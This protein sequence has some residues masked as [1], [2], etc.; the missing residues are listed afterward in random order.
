VT[1]LA[2]LRGLHETWVAARAAFNSAPID[3][4][5]LDRLMAAEE[6]AQSNLESAAVNALPGLLD[7][8]DA[9]RKATDA[10][11]RLLTELDCARHADQA[12]CAERVALAAALADASKV[13]S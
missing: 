12:A 8:L 5:D 9:L 7:E 13:R 10:S 6:D 4:T 2:W 11:Q 3:H 1:D